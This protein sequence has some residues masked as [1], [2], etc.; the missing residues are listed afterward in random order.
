MKPNN[1]S[2]EKSTNRLETFNETI[3]RRSILRGIG[4]AGVA[5]VGLGSLPRSV[6]AAKTIHGY[7][8]G[9]FNPT[10]VFYLEPTLFKPLPLPK[11]CNQNSQNTELYDDYFVRERATDTFVGELYLE[12]KKPNVPTGANNFYEWKNWN[13]CLETE[14]EPILKVTAQPI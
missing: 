9:D 6:A 13:G 4:V 3:K 14:G 12:S 10:D 1:G 5:G 2:S 8:Q 11:S 7:F